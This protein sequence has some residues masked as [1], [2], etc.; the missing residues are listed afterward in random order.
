M[1]AKVGV[2]NAAGLLDVVESENLASEVGFDDV[3]KHGQHGL[4]EHAA[5]GFDVGID[6]AG[7]GRVL[8]PVRELVGVCVENRIQAKRL[9]GAP[10]ERK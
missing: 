6:M 4:V 1:A 2:S 9:H 7:V 8:P 5:A 3:L 10:S